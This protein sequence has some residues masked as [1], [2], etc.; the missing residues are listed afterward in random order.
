MKVNF[1]PPSVQASGNFNFGEI[2]EK[3]PIGFPQDGGLLK[4]FSNLF[5][6]AHAWTPGKRSTI[7]HFV[8]HNN[9]FSQSVMTDCFLQM[10]YGAR[11]VYA[12]PHIRCVVSL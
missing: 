8:K 9:L 6:W 7:W 12:L 11:Q 2:L 3:K 10:I 4:P 1:Y 5:Y